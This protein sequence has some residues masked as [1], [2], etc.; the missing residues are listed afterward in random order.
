[1]R[2]GGRGARRSHITYT[3]FKKIELKDEVVT[4]NRVAYFRI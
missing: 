4:I 2:G 1:M 3:A